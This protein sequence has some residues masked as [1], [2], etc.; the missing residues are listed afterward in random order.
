MRR[1]V[2]RLLSRWYVPRPAP[3][4]ATPSYWTPEERAVI[5]EA[6]MYLKRIYVDSAGNWWLTP[7]TRTTR[8]VP[9]S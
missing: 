4:L 1:L 8:G 6:E 9:C 2:D 5:D 3:Q 7:P